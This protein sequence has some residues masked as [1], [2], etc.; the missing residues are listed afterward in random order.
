MWLKVTLIPCAVVRATSTTSLAALTMSESMDI[1]LNSLRPLRAQH[2]L[3]VIRREVKRLFRKMFGE[4]RDQVAHSDHAGRRALGVHQRDVAIIALPHQP[5]SGIDGIVQA[6]MRRAEGHHLLDRG[7]VTDR[8]AD[9][10]VEQ[11]ALGKQPDELAPLA[12]Q[13]A[14][15]TA[16]LHSF[17]RLA[18]ARATLDYRRPSQREVADLDL[19]H[20]RYN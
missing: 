7:R 10:L 11:I 16:G 13:R 17:D 5:H 8:L 1:S 9:N 14:S 18:Y 4:V 20:L 15:Q 12:D 19:Q 6:Q 3:I 2:Q